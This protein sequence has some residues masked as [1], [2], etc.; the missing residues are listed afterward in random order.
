[1]IYFTGH[2]QIIT[3]LD[4]TRQKWVNLVTEEAYLSSHLTT[5]AHLPHEDDV[6]AT[7]VVQSAGDTSGTVTE[8]LSI[9]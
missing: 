3:K 9:H 6:R 4:Q 7:L 8:V 5:G 1:M 2:I